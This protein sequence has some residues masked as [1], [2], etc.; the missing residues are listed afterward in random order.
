[1]QLWLNT[2]GID[3]VFPI[4]NENEIGSSVLE[5][6]HHFETNDSNE[7]EGPTQSEASK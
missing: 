4:L 1:M 7:D 6:T 5:I 3:L 2:G